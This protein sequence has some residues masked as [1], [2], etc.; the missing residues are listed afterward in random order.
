MSGRARYLVRGSRDAAQP[1]AL[2]KLQEDGAYATEL[3]TLEAGEQLQRDLAVY[4]AFLRG[5]SAASPITPIT[6]ADV[7]PDFGASRRGSN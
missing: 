3:L 5:R 4:C 2:I 7:E 1:L 6:P